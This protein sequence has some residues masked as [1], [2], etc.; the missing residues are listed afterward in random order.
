MWT[1]APSIQCGGDRKGANHFLLRLKAETGERVWHFQTTHHDT[2]DY[3]LPCQPALIT[4]RQ[5]RPPIDAV[6]QMSKM[7]LVFL[8]NRATGKRVFPIEKLRF[9]PRTCRGRNYGPHS[10]SQRGASAESP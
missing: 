3:D 4:M 2:W 9:P 1:G 6:A 8:F 5:Q 10:L 7:G